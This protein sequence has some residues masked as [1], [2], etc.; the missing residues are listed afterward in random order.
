[1]K[2]YNKIFN[3]KIIIF[4]KIIII[5]KKITILNRKINYKMRNNLDRILNIKKIIL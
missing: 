1:M 2:I 3:K 4:N 5:F